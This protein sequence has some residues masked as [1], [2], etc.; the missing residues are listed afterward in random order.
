MTHCPAAHPGRIELVGVFPQEEISFHSL[1]SS[2]FPKKHFH[3]EYNWMLESDYYSA[4]SDGC[5]RRWS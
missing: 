4:K 1:V 3:D 2:V 5:V